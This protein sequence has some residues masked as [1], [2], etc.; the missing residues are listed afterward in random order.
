MSD[1][2]RSVTVY[3]PGCT[4]IH[5]VGAMEIVD[6]C[7]FTEFSEVKVFWENGTTH[8][9]VGFPFILMKGPILK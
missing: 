7:V 2:Y 4:E 9:Y 6:I 1:T 8:T 5:T 3:T